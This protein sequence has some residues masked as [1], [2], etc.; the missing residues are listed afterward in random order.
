MRNAV[1][2]RH[3]NERV[4]ELEP[5]Y[6]DAKVT[7][8]TDLYILGSL[9]WPAKVAASV[10]GL[11]GN[12]QKGLEYLRQASASPHMESAVDAKIVLALFLRREQRYSEALQVVN[13][14]QNEF[15]RNF[16]MAGEYAHLLNAAGHGQEAIV[17]YRKV[18]A[19]CR[20]NAQFSELFT[21]SRHANAY[22]L[23]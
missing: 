11:S 10:A 18:L 4:L 8:G 19:G 14:M 20:S 22:G 2:A 1:A 13:G 21:A 7:V 15:P 9:S 17:A 6:V 12:K 3:D 16:L 23:R 5:N